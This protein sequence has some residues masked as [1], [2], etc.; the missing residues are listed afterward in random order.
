MA[1]CR[2]RSARSHLSL[3]LSRDLALASALSLSRPPPSDKNSCVETSPSL[4]LHQG[5]GNMPIRSFYNTSLLFTAN[6]SP[7]ALS[8]IL[9]FVSTVQLSAWSPKG[10]DAR[11]NSGT[12]L[13]NSLCE[14]QL[15][16]Q[17]QGRRRRRKRGLDER[18]RAQRTKKGGRWEV[19]DQ[20]AS[21]GRHDHGL[22]AKHTGD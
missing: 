14:R 5:S 16:A 4:L 13:A 17:R 9:L 21:T 3:S 6:C 19:G 18:A 22:I 10:W 20:R 12:H 2:Q 8:V 1:T 15:K 11:G 7:T